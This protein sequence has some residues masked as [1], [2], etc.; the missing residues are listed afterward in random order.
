MLSVTTHSRAMFPTSTSHAPY[1]EG[2]DLHDQ[3]DTVTGIK[4]PPAMLTLPCGV[5][6]A[7]AP[8]HNHFGGSN[9]DGQHQET[10]ICLQLVDVTPAEHSSGVHPH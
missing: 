3:D 1:Q 8:D 2:H 5:C 10:I 9:N 6:G 7:P 4:R